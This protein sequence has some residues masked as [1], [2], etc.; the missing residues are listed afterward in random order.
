MGLLDVTKVNSGTLIINK[1]SFNFNKM[2]SETVE[3][4]E[5]IAPKNKITQH[6][7]AVGLV[8]SDEE[9]IIQVL[10]NLLTNAIK[11]SPENSEIIINTYQQKDEVLFSIQDF[12]VGISLTE[13]KNIFNQFHRISGP[14]QHTYPGLG[15]GLFISAEIIKQLGGKIWVESKEDKGSTFF[16]S[17]PA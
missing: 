8:F 14:M 12:G 9:R 13:Q 4:I 16:F 7:S 6:L 10:T 5:I 11:Y 1:T 3:E 15:L 17:I 2:V